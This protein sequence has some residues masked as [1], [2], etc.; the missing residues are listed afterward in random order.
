MKNVLNKMSG[1]EKKA[2]DLIEEKI[3]V[4]QNIVSN[5]I[6]NFETYKSESRK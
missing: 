2:V 4:L 5:L 3:S 1:Q 6:N